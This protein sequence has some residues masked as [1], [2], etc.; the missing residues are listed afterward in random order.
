MFRRASPPARWFLTKALD[1]LWVPG[2]WWASAACLR[3][4]GAPGTHH[5]RLRS[6][7]K[8]LRGG[9]TLLWPC[10]GSRLAGFGPASFSWAWVSGGDAGPRRAVE[11]VAGGLHG[12]AAWMLAHGVGPVSL[13]RPPLWLGRICPAPALSE[14]WSFVDSVPVCSFSF[15]CYSHFA[16]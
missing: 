14:S 1:F 15:V 12:A 5:K 16:F 6:A 2:P 9:T 11:T 8:P 4:D 10:S 7:W 13:P 3:E